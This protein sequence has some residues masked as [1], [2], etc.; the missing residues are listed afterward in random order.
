MKRIALI[1]A[2]CVLSLAILLTESWTPLGFNHGLLYLFPLVLLRHQPLM[3]Q[4]GAAALM[5]VMILL[6]YL[7]SPTGFQ[8]EYVILNRVLSG[9]A[10]WA[11]VIVQI[12]GRGAGHG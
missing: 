8:Q 4:T 10:I 3:L 9:I 12:D 6:G 1:I 5:S 2:A 11:V 7:G